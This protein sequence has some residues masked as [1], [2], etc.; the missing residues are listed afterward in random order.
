MKWF[1][2]KSFFSQLTASLM[3]VHNN[4]T[5]LIS[6][7]MHHEKRLKG[8]CNETQLKG[9]PCSLISLYRVCKYIKLGKRLVMVMVAVMVDEEVD[10][11]VDE[12][13]FSD[14]LHRVCT[15]IR[16]DTFSC[17]VVGMGEAIIGRG[18]FILELLQIVGCYNFSFFTNY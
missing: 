5:T 1:H 8:L 14:L 13:V 4:L 3:A 18:R 16:L 9:F 15:R 12:E 10:K 6:L 11:E 7:K 2:K 17:L